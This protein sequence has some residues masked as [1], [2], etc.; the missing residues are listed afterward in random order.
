M[1]IIEAGGIIL[2]RQ[3]GVFD[4][5]QCVPMRYQRLMRGMGKILTRFIVF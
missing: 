1:K 2:P 5:L 4:R 3:I